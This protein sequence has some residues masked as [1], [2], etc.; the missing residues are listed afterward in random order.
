MDLQL[1]NTH[2]DK[3]VHAKWYLKKKKKKKKTL[4][5]LHGK[6]PDNS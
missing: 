2:M 6:K 1:S 4:T 5:D 3:S